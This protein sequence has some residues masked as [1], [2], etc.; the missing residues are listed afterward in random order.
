MAFPGQGGGI[1]SQQ[2]EDQLGDK[3]QNIRLLVGRSPK[4]GV[5]LLVF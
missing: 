1:L 5:V 3:F 2:N 4:Y